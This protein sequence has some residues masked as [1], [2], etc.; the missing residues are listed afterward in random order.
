MKAA[1]AYTIKQLGVPSVELMERA[2]AACVEYMERQEWDISRVCIVCGSGN[3]GGDGFAIGRMLLAKGSSVTLVFAG[4]MESRTE[5]TVYQ[6]E[7]FEKTGGNVDREWRPQEYSTVID[8]LFGVGLSRDI[9]GKYAE[10]IDRMNESPGKKLAVDVPSGI[11][12]ST[13]Q[14]LGTAFG[15]DATVTFQECKLGLV[16]YPG[17]E[18][19]G[20]VEVPDIGID[21]S[22]VTGAADAAY[23]MDKRDTGKML[24]ERSADS[25]KGTFGRLLLVAGCKGMAGAAYLSAYAAYRMGAGLVQIYTAEEN[26]GILQQLIPEAIV[27]AYEAYNEQELAEKLLWADVVCVG[28]GIG[29]SEISGNILKF[30]LNHVEVPCIIDADGLNLLAADR[31]LMEKLKAGEYVLTPHMKELSR[32]TGHPVAY[33]KEN[34]R[35]VMEQFTEQYGVTLVQKDARTLVGAPKSQTY[36]NRTG[37]AAMAKAGSGDVLAGVIAALTAQ[38]KSGYEA[39]VLGVYLHGL[40][41]D[42]ARERLGRY[43]VLARDLAEH[44]GT[45]ITMIE[46]E[47]TDIDHETVHKGLCQN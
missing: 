11:S 23:T 42:A 31:G 41:G 35:A 40:A 37:N 19:A 3:N 29:M 38:G 25:N 9:T 13:G 34:R 32:L 33:L 24:P 16:L 7:L 47:R 36:V 20:R 17:C 44:I 28:P 1:D 4:R 18:Y 6:M 45:A 21:S 46:N 27:S 14:I 43:S 22:V 26:R 12:S 8:A 5:E 10:L 39:A 15:A 2:A 30:I